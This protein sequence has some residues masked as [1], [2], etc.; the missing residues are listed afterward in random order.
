MSDE[1]LKSLHVDEIH[2]ILRLLEQEYRRCRANDAYIFDDTIIHKI[3]NLLDV[4]I[5]AKLIQG[6]LE[7]FTAEMVGGV[8]KITP[9]SPPQKIK[10]DIFVDGEQVSQQPKKQSDIEYLHFFPSDN[11]YF[12]EKSLSCKCAPV[13]HG[14]AVYHQ[15]SSPASIGS[16][17]DSLAS[18]GFV[19]VGTSTS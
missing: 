15:S 7:I 17:C 2:K 14:Y 5:K 12:H 3:M 1:V 16:V 18:I 8:L 9:K 13:I 11:Y 4:E 6:A 19:C 10:I